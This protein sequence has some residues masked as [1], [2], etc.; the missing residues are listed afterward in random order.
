MRLAGSPVMRGLGGGMDDQLD[1]AGVLFEDAYHAF[2]VPDIEVKR[3]ERAP[4]LVGQ[5]TNGRSRRSLRTEEVRAHVVVQPDHVV[6]LLGK[7]GHRF[8][9]NQATGSSY[10]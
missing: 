8:R 7:V 2:S 9:T 1:L 10:Y 3:P 6:A 5:A 4:Q